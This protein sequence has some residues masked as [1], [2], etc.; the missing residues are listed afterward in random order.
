MTDLKPAFDP[1]KPFEAVSDKPPF[2]PSKPF[3]AASQGGTPVVP[4]V[5]VGEDIAKSILPD[6][7]SAATGALGIGGD[8]GS[9][10]SSGVDYAGS[11]LGVAP[12]KVQQ[13]KDMMKAG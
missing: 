11:K 8:A 12:D 10:L 3:E 9:L 1:S 2:D 5:G 7:A 6:I 4:K 13:F